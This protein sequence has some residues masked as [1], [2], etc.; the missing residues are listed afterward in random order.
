MKDKINKIKVLALDVDGV[1][2]DGKII[3]DNKGNELKNFDVQDGF[4]IV[5]FKK[6]GFK[7][8]IISAR[9]TK[10]VSIRAKDLGIDKIYQNAYPKLKAYKKMLRDFKVNDEEVCFIGDD[11]PD[12][13]V[14]EKVGFA[15]TVPN[16]VQEVKQA[17]DYITH[18]TGGAGAVREL[19][20][21]ILK[22]QGKWIKATSSIR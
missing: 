16:A 3:V 21:L 10:A 6:A 5:F 15:A 12:L 1:L 9:S 17:A 22:T 14:L 20:E 18:K 8:A 11:L 7:T 19:I 4:G 13:P 2:T